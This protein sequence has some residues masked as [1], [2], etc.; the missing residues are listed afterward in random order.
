MYKWG[1]EW[2]YCAVMW[3][4]RTSEPQFY[5]HAPRYR[6]VRTIHAK[7]KR[8]P[9]LGERRCM[10]VVVTTSFTARAMSTR[11]LEAVDIR[12]APERARGNIIF[13]RTCQSLFR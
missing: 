2:W 12:P 4:L 9:I 1:A 3:L 5:A 13:V 7:R 8:S 6:E 10:H 11:P